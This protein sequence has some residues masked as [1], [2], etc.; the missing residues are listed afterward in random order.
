MPD[1]NTP[2]LPGHISTRTSG[3]FSAFH[4]L[5]FMGRWGAWIVLLASLLITFNAWYF[6]RSETT[7]RAQARFDFRV[8]TIETGIYERLQA[9]EFLLR[10]GVRSFCDFRRSHAGGLADLCNEV[11]D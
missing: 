9:Y 4:L 1:K 3:I 2:E 5:G 7:K 11:A 10:G 6:A 8:K